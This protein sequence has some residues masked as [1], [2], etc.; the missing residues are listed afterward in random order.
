MEV[1]SGHLKDVEWEEGVLT[2]Q[3]R[4]GSVYQYADVPIGIYE[5]LVGAGSKSH[6][7]RENV[8]GKFEHTK[9]G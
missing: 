5:E 1:D 8:K 6:F 2:I 7:F 3:F 9:V 4:D